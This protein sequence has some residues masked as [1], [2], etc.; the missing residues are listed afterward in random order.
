MSIII[1]TI[2]IVVISVIIIIIAA[3]LQSGVSNRAARKLWP[4]DLVLN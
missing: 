2:I 4:H 1:T 3:S